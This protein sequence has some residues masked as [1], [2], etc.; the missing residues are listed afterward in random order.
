M[1]DSREAVFDRHGFCINCGC[2]V[3]GVYEVGI[4][5][6]QKLINACDVVKTGSF[7]FNN[8]EKQAERAN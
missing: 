4:S 3:H 2:D 7:N 1:F 5:C 6:L 8:M